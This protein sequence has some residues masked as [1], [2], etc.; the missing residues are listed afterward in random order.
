MFIN[1]LVDALAVTLGT[2]LPTV[3]IELIAAH[4]KSH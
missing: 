4:M 3:V 1:S 2:L